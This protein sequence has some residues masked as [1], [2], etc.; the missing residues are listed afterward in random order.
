MKKT[1]SLLLTVLLILSSFSLQ[2]FTANAEG[3]TN[4]TTKNEIS[5]KYY[6]LYG[7]DGIIDED[8][9][10]T[11]DYSEVEETE[12]GNSLTPGISPYWASKESS[13]PKEK[14]VTHD[15]IIDAANKM[16]IKDGGDSI[17]ELY[18]SLVKYINKRCDTSRNDTEGNLAQYNS[19]VI[20]GKKNYHAT[21][22][23]L[24]T[25]AKSIKNYETGSITNAVQTANQAGRNVL[26]AEIKGTQEYIN[27][28]H[29]TKQIVKDY[30]ND[31]G[32]CYD[33]RQ[34]YGR[35]CKYIVY[36][37]I[38]HTFGDIYAHRT[39]IPP[40][41]VETIMNPPEFPYD[42]DNE[43]TVK[44]YFN[45][46]HF[47]ALKR[48]KL[49]DM[50]KKVRTKDEDGNV[51]ETSVCFSEIK[52]DLYCELATI[53]GDEMNPEEEKLFESIK[54]KIG[55][56]YIDNGKFYPGRVNEAIYAVKYF[57][58]NFSFCNAD[59]VYYSIEPRTFTL[60]NFETYSE[61]INI[62]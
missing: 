3:N 61:K 15:D 62:E 57:V 41:A 2:I 14:K 49:D 22:Y 42:I 51:S 12:S 17:P 47:V 43:Q 4:N 60:K 33:N 11:W 23:Y 35:R 10:Y 32:T 50:I 25:F 8:K 9:E 40:K 53:A 54:E 27:L 21:I 59:S 19:I 5:Q 13:D 16:A 6:E 24:W 36:G 46:E 29:F 28:F 52:S 26:P 44:W 58:E 39:I 30:Y 31:T 37:I 34:T 1:I 7:E 20:H 56:K 38:C 45:P 48:S 55:K 18:L